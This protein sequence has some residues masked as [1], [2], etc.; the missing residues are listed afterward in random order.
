LEYS[1]TPFF[2]PIPFVSFP[3]SLTKVHIHSAKRP[4]SS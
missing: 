4:L 1:G 2:M 3:F